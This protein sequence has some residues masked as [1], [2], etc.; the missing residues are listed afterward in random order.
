MVK[1]IL[2]VRRKPG[3]DR[4]AFQRYYEFTHAPLASSVMRQCKKYVRN[5]VSEE[6]SGPL[7]F[8]VITEFWFDADGPWEEAQRNLSDPGIQQLL[9]DDEL[10]FMDR[11]SMRVF[12]V[13]E[14]ESDPGQLLGNLAST[15]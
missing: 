2:L 14:C 6:L 4:K 5:F 11:S 12:T 13:D 10:R 3:T 7:D 1:L 9:E 15:V 8:D